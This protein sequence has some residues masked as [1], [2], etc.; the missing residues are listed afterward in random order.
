MV[1]TRNARPGE[2]VVAPG[3]TKRFLYA[4]LVRSSRVFG[5]FSFFFANQ[6][7]STLMHTSLKS[8]GVS[9]SAPWSGRRYWSASGGTPFASYDVSTPSFTA[10][11]PKVLSMP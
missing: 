7:L 8:I 9:W 4:G 6:V 11:D 5:G 3:V 2:D 1:A 10:R